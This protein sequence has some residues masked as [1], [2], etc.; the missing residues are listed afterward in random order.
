[1]IEQMIDK[2]LQEFVGN[3][4][5]KGQITFG[6]VRRLQRGCLPTGATGRKELETLI[7]L[8]SKI[9]RADKTWAQ[10][11]VAAVIDFVA[12][13]QEYD[14]PLGEPADKWVDGLL[15]APSTNLGRRIARQIRRELAR[16]RAVE[17]T[18]RHPEGARHCHAQHSSPLGMPEN[19]FATVWSEMMLGPS[20][21][22]A[23]QLTSKSI[24]L[25]A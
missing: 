9:A 10:W 6:D 7:A 12:A 24:S 25:A 1:M 5:A 3:I 16:L 14:H 15:A 8:N 4:V 20:H 11:L 13:G 17:S 21:R 19:D 18:Q 23:L 2:R 22:A